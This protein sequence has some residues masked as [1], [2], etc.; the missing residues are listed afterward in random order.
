MGFSAFGAFR[1]RSAAMPAA[2]LSQRRISGQSAQAGFAGRADGC[3]KVHHGLGMVAGPCAGVRVAA[4][5]ASVGLDR[6]AGFHREEA[7]D[8][9]LDIA[10]DHGGGFV[11]GDGGNGCGGVGANA[12]KSQKT[13]ASG[14]KAAVRGNGAGAFQEVAGA[15]VIAEPG[16][17]KPSPRILGRGKGLNGGPAAVKRRK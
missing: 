5:L 17:F 9:T 1:G 12:G 13:V 4:R 3:A 2:W 6:A 11:E 8:D 10:I 15:G 16:P 7:R 14:G